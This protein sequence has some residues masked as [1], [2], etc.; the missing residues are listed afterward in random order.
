MCEFAPCKLG[1]GGTARGSPEPRDLGRAGGGR[2]R[3]TTAARVFVGL[4]HVTAA[5]EERM[6]RMIEMH[7]G[8]GA[9]VRGAL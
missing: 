4:V 5:P 6:K 9:R 2:A 8:R 1:F 7:R 3:G